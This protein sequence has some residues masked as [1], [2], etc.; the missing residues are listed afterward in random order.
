MLRQ[1]QL[2][3]LKGLER[4]ISR[5]KLQDN[6]LS[7]FRGMLTSGETQDGALLTPHRVENIVRTNLIESYNTGRLDMF[8][9]PDVADRI[10]AVEYS[11]I[12][13]SRTTPFCRAWDGTVL[14][15]NDQQL[16]QITPPNHF[17]CRSI[18]VP[19]MR[20]EEFEITE[21]LPSERPLEGF[22]I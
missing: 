6:L 8:R 15:L 7:L 3:I 11:A 22:R 16:D 4:G 1:V 9:H 10:G 19:I 17:Q 14:S 13:D 20:V 2:I 21:R 12:I 5:T 18:L